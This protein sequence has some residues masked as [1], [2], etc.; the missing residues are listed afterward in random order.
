M[1]LTSVFEL[2]TPSM[3]YGLILWIGYGNSVVNPFIYVFFSRE[4]RTVITKDLQRLR[5]KCTS[6]WSKKQLAEMWYEWTLLRDRD[7]FL[8]YLVPRYLMSTKSCC[9]L[10]FVYQVY[11]RAVQAEFCLC[12]S[13]ERECPY[14]RYMDVNLYCLSIFW[15]H[16]W[17]L[18]KVF[19]FCMNDI[20][21][22]L[23][24]RLRIIVIN[25]K[26]TLLRHF[27]SIHV[28]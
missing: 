6:V 14:Y 9:V 13:M 24:N 2:E 18:G 20:N 5:Q 15:C 27:R 19:R 23:I 3:V 26:G 7:K 17:S 21:Y 28:L 10:R 16:M 4:F 11:S 22:T 8:Q 12:S 1:P 25:E